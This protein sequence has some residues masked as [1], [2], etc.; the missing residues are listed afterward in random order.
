DGPPQP[1]WKLSNVVALAES[2]AK[3]K[4]EAVGTEPLT[5]R[6][7]FNGTNLPGANASTLTLTN[8]LPAQSGPYFVVVSNVFGV[9]TNSGASRSVVPALLTFQ[10]TNQTV[11]G[12][13]TV[14]LGLG[15]DG[16][17]LTYQWHFFGTNLPDATNVALTLSNVTTN[18]AGIYSVAISNHYG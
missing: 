5:Y 6:W 17:D 10:P 1:L 4:G 12:G 15:A 2:T 18:H 7:Y 14:T 11:Y 13:D 3:F 16:T 8:V 9:A